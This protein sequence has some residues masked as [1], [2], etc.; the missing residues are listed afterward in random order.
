MSESEDTSITS[1]SKARTLEEIAD[2]WDNHSLP[3]HWDQIHEV[4]DEPTYFDQSHP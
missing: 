3:D 1:I 4:E 2:Y